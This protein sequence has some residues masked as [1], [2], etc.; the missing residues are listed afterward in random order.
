M[1]IHM[2]RIIRPPPP[3][4]AAVTMIFKGVSHLNVKGGSLRSIP[5]ND[6]VIVEA[7]DRI[8]LLFI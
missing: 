3:A 5:V 6:Y 4:T 2:K 8:V 1:Q 7:I